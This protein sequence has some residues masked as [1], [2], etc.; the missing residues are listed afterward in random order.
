MRTSDWTDVSNVNLSGVLC[1]RLGQYD[2][3]DEHGGPIVNISSGSGMTYKRGPT[4]ATSVP[5]PGSSSFP[6]AW[7]WSGLTVGSG[8]TR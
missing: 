4:L 7:R 5:R 2:V 6:A 8:S 1:N 3:M